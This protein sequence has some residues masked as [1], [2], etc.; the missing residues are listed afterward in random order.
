MKRNSVLD[1]KSPR[2]VQVNITEKLNN[3]ID[4]LGK[5]HKRAFHLAGPTNT[6]D[7]AYTWS[8]LA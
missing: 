7:F 6:N 5:L 2:K 1:W 8:N 4:A 3:D